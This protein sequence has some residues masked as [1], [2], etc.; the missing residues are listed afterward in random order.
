LLFAFVNYARWLEVNPEIALREA[1]LRFQRRFKSLER[2][3]KA[4]GREL[5]HMTLDEM[6]APWKAS[7]EEEDWY[8]P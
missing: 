8:L 6:D 1:N 5:D 3:A 7:K 2:K 4:Q